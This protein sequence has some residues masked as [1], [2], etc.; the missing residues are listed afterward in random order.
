MTLEIRF[1]ILPEWLVKYDISASAKI[2]YAGIWL[3]TDSEERKA[4][5]SRNRLS[6]DLNMSTS[7]IDRAIKELKEINA[8]VV[9]GRIRPDGGRTS[10]NYELRV[11]QPRGLPSYTTGGLARKQVGAVVADDE[12]ITITNKQKPIKTRKRDLLF[13]EMCNGLGI[14]WNDSTDGELSKVRGAVKQL[15]NANATPEQL[16]RVIDH[17]KKNWKVQISAPAISNNWSKLKNEMKEKEVKVHNCENDGHGWIDLD[18]I[19][20]CRFCK[21][22]KDKKR[23]DN[24]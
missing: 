16:K 4:F 14:D 20:Q 22:E 6:K 8:I 12:A 19:Y 11:T 1:A 3:Y 13:E 10:N 2:V 17:Y 21:A 15:R 23:E 5:P 18:I 9:K 7:T 24:K